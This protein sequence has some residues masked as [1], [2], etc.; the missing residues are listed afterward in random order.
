MRWRG[1]K[2]ANAAGS[3]PD[4]AS[5]NITRLPPMMKAF[6]LVRMPPTP[7]MMRA[8]PAHPPPHSALA[9]SAVAI[10]ALPRASASRPSA[11]AKEI[12]PY[13][14]TASRSEPI[15]SQPMRRA[16]RSISSA[17]W[18]STSKPTNSA[19]A[20][21]STVRTPVAG[22]AM[23]GV[24][25]ARSPCAA[26]PVKSTRPASRIM[27]V[28]MLCTMAATRMPMTLI[29]V[30][31]MAAPTPINTKPKWTGASSRVHNVARRMSG[32]MYSRAVGSATDSNAHTTQYA[33][34][35]A[36]VQ[37]NDQPGPSPSWV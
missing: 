25:L 18:G 36:Q 30:M 33:I 27:A 12:A 26:A 17:D 9:A 19:G 20:M 11:A 1:C 24:A 6:Q 8:T 23:S 4:S 22:V 34:K 21:I 31:A 16:G 13:H 2:R 35:S 3:T 7:P 14:A 37:T 5:A 10:V 29:H 32:R 28:T 15:R